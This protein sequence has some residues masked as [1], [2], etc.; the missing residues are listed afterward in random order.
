MISPTQ[1]T[2]KR[3]IINS[4]FHFLFGNSNSAEEI[5][6]I[7]NNMAIK[8]QNQDI[9]NSQIQETFNF[10]N[11]TYTETDSSRLLLISLQKDILQINSTVHHLSKELKSLFHDRNFFVIKFQ[12]RSCLA[13]LCNGINS[14]K[15][16]ILSILDQVSI[17][18][19]Q[20]LKPVLLYP[21]DLKSLLTKLETQ[22]VSHP[23]LALPQWNCANIW[24]MYKFMKLWSFMM[25]DTLY[26]IL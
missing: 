14:V 5:K 3:G 23:R 8:E 25:S 2:P 1:N 15:I 10:I 19:S 6:A 4:L 16:D 21:L 20:K 22:L 7:K 11:L 24:Y 26:V 12:F 18:S 9:L 13:T 17:I